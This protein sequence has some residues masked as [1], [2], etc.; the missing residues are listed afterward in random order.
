MSSINDKPPGEELLVEQKGYID[1]DGNSH[2]L[3]GQPRLSPG[4]SY[5]IAANY[6]PTQDVM[7][8]L[9]GSLSA[10]PAADQQTID[11]LVS[12]YHAA[13]RN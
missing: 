3:A 5:V 12:S 8:V 4:H 1:A 10:R 9:A 2:V 13:E 11:E 6:D 7:I